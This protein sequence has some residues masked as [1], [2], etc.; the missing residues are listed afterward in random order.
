MDVGLTLQVRFAVDDVA[1]SALH[2]RAF[3][4]TSTGMQPWAT[5]LARHALTWVGAFNGD[6]LIGFV[7]LGWDGGAHAF[8]L[9]TA[10]DPACQRRGVGRALV[11][12]A[13]AE[14]TRAGC[15]WVHVDYEP[16]LMS[17]YRDACGFRPTDAGLLHL[18]P[19]AADG[20]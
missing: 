9:D 12:A 14:A 6:V 7:S 16:Q 20:H 15:E 2:D 1:L 10:V 3:G 19:H 17:F 11:E 5:R 8:L 13:V 4:S 18:P